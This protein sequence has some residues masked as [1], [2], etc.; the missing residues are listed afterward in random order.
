MRKSLTKKCKLLRY[1]E[2]EKA[3]KLLHALTTS[4]HCCT[5]VSVTLGN[6]YWFIIS[7][8]SAA[9]RLHDGMLRAIL[10]A[11]MIFFHTNPTGRIINRFSRDIGDVDR[12]VV[13]CVSM[14]LSQFWQLLSTFVLIGIVSTISLWAIMPLMILF[15]SAYLYYQVE[16]LF[17]LLWLFQLS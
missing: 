16:Y 12:N 8:L 3:C 5:Q 9:K 17:I 13:N 14:F 1:N 11:P 2:V 15:Y 4:Y 10:R 7:S 6:S